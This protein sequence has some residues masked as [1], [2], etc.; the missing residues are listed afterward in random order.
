MNIFEALLGNKK[1]SSLIKKAY[2]NYAWKLWSGEKNVNIATWRHIDKLNSASTFNSFVDSLIEYDFSHSDDEN[3][4]EF[5][6]ERI[7][8][9]FRTSGIGYWKRYTNHYP[10]WNTYCW[11]FIYEEFQDKLNKRIYKNLNKVFGIDCKKYKNEAAAWMFSYM[12]SGYC[13]RGKFSDL[14]EYYSCYK[15]NKSNFKLQ[16]NFDLAWK[17]ANNTI[18][19]ADKAEAIIIFNDIKERLIK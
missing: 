19:M 13:W 4:I 9:V 10:E 1:T 7:A 8:T 15:F 6:N 18:T 17:I 14:L 12:I 16:D 3:S 11:D 2:K 5:Y